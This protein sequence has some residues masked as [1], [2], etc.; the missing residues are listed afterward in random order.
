MLRRLYQVLLLLITIF[1]LYIV[2][3]RSVITWIEHSPAHF[4]SLI[5]TT[6]NSTINFETIDINQSWLGFDVTINAFILENKYIKLDAKKIH[7]D[8]KKLS[9]WLI[10]A[11][12]GEQAT[13][14]DVNIILKQKREIQFD[15]K[16]LAKHLIKKNW[17]TINI[18]N[19]NINSALHENMQL[20]L[21][22]IQ[23]NFNDGWSFSGISKILIDN[24]EQLILQ[25]YGQFSINNWNQPTN[26]EISTYVMSTD[27]SPVNKY[28][29]ILSLI[30]AQKVYLQVK[31]LD[32]NTIRPIFDFT[33][34]NLNIPKNIIN[35]IKKLTLN[36][37]NA[38]FN[39]KNN[40]LEK[41]AFEV[42]TFNFPQQQKMVGIGFNNLF[43][44]KSAAQITIDAKQG[45]NL[46][47][48]Y[49]KD[50]PI[51][52]HANSAYVLNFDTSI[53][54]W[55]LEKAALKMGNI[56]LTL[57]AKTTL[58]GFVDLKL[59]LEPDNIATVKKYL[60]FGLMSA[61]LE[62]WLKNALVQGDNIKAFVH[63]NGK[64]ADFP[65][66]NG[67]GKFY[68]QATIDNAKLKFSPDWPAVEN[69]AAKLTFTP[70]NLSIMANNAN[71]KNVNLSDVVVNINNL[72]SKKIAVN[73]TG[74][75][76]S[77]ATNAINFLHTT[78]LLE[79]ANVDNFIKNNLKLNGDIQVNL[80]K[81][82]I[83][84]VGFEDKAI[85]V[86]GNI[87]LQTVDINLF[88]DWHINDL[89]GELQFS[90][91]S[92][93]STQKLT[94]DAK[95]KQAQLSNSLFEITTN[96]Q[97]I[98]IE[99]TGLTKLTNEFLE[100]TQK[101]QGLIK[102]PLQKN[103]NIEVSANM[104]LQDSISKLPAPL[105]NFA[106]L[107]YPKLSA[108]L[109][110]KSNYNLLELKLS[111]QFMANVKL[112]N[113][114]SSVNAVN[115]IAANNTV[116]KNAKQLNNG[117]SFH[118]NIKT[119]DLD[120]WK[121]LIPN[122]NNKPSDIY[123]KNW[124]FSEINIQ[125][126]KLLD[127]EFNDITLNVIPKEASNTSLQINTE[128][129]SLAIHY[130]IKQNQYI[131]NLN[132]LNIEDLQEVL[133]NEDTCVSM[134]T[135]IELPNIQVIGNNIYIEDKY[136]QKLN[137]N[138]TDDSK[139]IKISNFLAHLGSENI[140]IKGQYSYLKSNSISN[141]TG[142]IQST[143]IEKVLAFLR[144]RQGITGKG[145][146]VNTNL[147]WQGSLNCF[148]I[149]TLT[150]HI[151]YNLS[152][153]V[154]KDA[155]PGIARLISLLSVES[156]ARRLRLD[157]TGITE[158]GM[159]FDSIRADGKFNQGIFNLNQLTLRAPAANATMLGTINLV[160]EQLDLKAEITPAIGGTL[161][162]IAAI[163]G[164]A[165][166]IA[167]LLAYA[168]LKAVPFINVDLVT[169]TYEIKGTFDSPDI[170]DKGLGLDIFNVYIDKS[171]TNVLDLE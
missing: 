166:P 158:P 167:G 48:N 76:D 118:G 90:E 152:Q 102:L 33:L 120:G 97:F 93:Y 30:N 15:T 80:T 121:E 109:K 128:N 117:Y 5:E 154:I 11:R 161:P 61:P 96:K 59:H 136:I 69:F 142:S 2:A 40:T 35:N 145:L 74:K 107:N 108:N 4:I 64:L 70:Y 83:P 25:H 53:K 29:I 132:K 37:I 101:W 36:D 78:P 28:P 126:L 38:N 26:G 115:F 39:L 162:T 88:N 60:P 65:F 63:L 155:E 164:V 112:S 157:P 143:N 116:Q 49:I 45:I 54:E 130:D 82:L 138:I 42:S 165:T 150:G 3:V 9:P 99:A 149:E 14:T 7:F 18:S 58:D 123:Q 20:N 81:L 86:N 6:T 17:R 113:D 98:Q 79:L 140:K 71:I 89:N 67:K 24:K 62:S 105:N 31:L 169:Y 22:Q 84:I 56:P 57:Q 75:A 73:I 127:R 51:N 122:T 129:I 103:N 94:G 68:A 114:F 170:M 41:I 163:S 159:V 27:K 156:L 171:D 23:S 50:T 160:T 44:S 32:I 141:I 85:K 77:S 104:F 72:N 87:D 10:N 146:H 95:F 52:L 21:Q 147:S 125:T 106:K 12:Y 110:I 46:Y 91:N 111:D 168:F 43:F 66:K 100:G 137:F 135:D 34:Q 133:S 124:Q 131:I 55:S 1:I 139:Q 144:T 92:V 153:G 47:A 19:I 8:F 151:N 16:F 119:L 134:F 13:I 148:S